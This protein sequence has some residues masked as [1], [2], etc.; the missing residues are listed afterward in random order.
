MKLKI[1]SFIL[2]VTTFSS[3][4]Q[5][6]ILEVKNPFPRVGDECEVEYTIKSDTFKVSET[7]SFKEQMKAIRDKELGRGTMKFTKLINDTGY[8]SFGPFTF[9]VDKRKMQS[10]IISLYFDNPLPNEKSGIWIR[11]NSYL[12][13]EYLVIEQ[14]ISGEWI[15][16]KTTDNSI[17][18][19]FQKDNDEFI[20]IDK[21]KVDNKYIEFDFSYSTSKSQDVE[22]NGKSETVSYKISL[23][24]IT[25]TGLF[26]NKFKLNKS[27]LTSL[28]IKQNDFEFYVK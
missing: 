5:I 21:E 2:C 6:V 19:E 11:Q 8:T 3:Y 4:S 26:K 13:Q 27:N 17:S 12:G 24:K 22:I 9:L 10:D 23:Y 20:E 14:R 7:I 25:K 18:S 15:T 28:P 1:L 16:T